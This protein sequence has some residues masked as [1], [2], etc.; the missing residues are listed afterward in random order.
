MRP[1]FFRLVIAVSACVALI[2]FAVYMKSVS[3]DVHSK[4]VDDLKASASKEGMRE[5]P[6]INKIREEA[7]KNPA[8]AEAQ[9]T[10]AHALFRHGEYSE[11]LPVFDTA[12][13]LNPSDAQLFFERAKIRENTGHRAN[14]IPDYEQAVFLDPKHVPAMLRAASLLRWEKDTTRSIGWCRRVV[15]IEPDNAEAHKL[16]GAALSQEGDYSRAI[17]EFEASLRSNPKDDSVLSDMAV[18]Y[19]K[20]GD[21][22]SAHDAYSRACQLNQ[23]N[24]R[25]CAGSWRLQTAQ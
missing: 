19:E 1:L 14:A 11:A 9:A 20:T 2:L 21:P 3:R 13:H 4:V 12:I 24:S 5:L 8:S 15:E 25:A 10:L 18:A 7:Q 16:W 23:R 17:P 22:R 6:D